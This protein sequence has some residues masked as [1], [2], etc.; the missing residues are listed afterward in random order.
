MKKNKKKNNIKNN[1]I[2]SLSYLN[3]H[4]MMV[5]KIKLKNK[6]ISLKE[7]YWNYMKNKILF[8]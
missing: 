5:L 2:I 8:M 7:L 3:T 6:L 1:K 4:K